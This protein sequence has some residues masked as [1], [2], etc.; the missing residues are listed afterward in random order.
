MRCVML[1]I[2]P[3]RAQPV[4]GEQ[5]G[6]T[7]REPVTSAPVPEALKHKTGVGT[8]GREIGELARQ[9]R[10]A[11]LVDCDMVEIAEVQPGFPQAICDRL[12]RKSGPVLDAAKSLF[13]HR[14]DEFSVP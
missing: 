4:T 6:E 3:F 11:V 14:R 12:R 2:V 13:L 8:G 1:D 5:G 9:L 10:R 7:M